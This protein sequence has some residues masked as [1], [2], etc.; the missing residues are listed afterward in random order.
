[1]QIAKIH[2]I[3]SPS[4]T[5]SQELQ[6]M[7]Y[8]IIK[9]TKQ[10]DA[11]TFNYDVDRSVAPAKVIHDFSCVFPGVSPGERLRCID[12]FSLIIPLNSGWRVPFCLKGQHAQTKIMLHASVMVWTFSDQRLIYN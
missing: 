7:I 6:K 1:M 4:Q 5:T 3:L 12:Q 8:F 10:S 11:L 9:C 2:M